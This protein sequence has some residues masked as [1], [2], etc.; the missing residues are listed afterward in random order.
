MHLSTH[1]WM[2]AEKLET[3]PR[4]IGRFGLASIG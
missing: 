2:R 3:T 1:K 4:R